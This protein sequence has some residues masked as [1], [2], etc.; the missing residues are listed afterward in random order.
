MQSIYHAANS[1]D[2]HVLVQRLAGHDIEAFVE[3][4]NLQSAGGEMAFGATVR[5][6][7]DGENVDQARALVKVFEEEKRAANTE[8]AAPIGPARS[9][10]LNILLGA[11]L[12]AGAML[13]WHHTPTNK[14]EED[15]NGDGEADLYYVYAPS[16]HVVR[17]DAD[18]NFDGKLDAIYQ[19]DN[20]GHPQSGELDED[21]DG[22]FDL[23]EEYLRGALSA[24]QLN[25]NGNIQEVRSFHYGVLNQ[26]EYLDASSGTPR[27]RA[28]FRAGRLE[29]A[30]LDTDLDGKFDT[31]VQYNVQ[32]DEQGRSFIGA[33]GL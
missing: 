4:E 25:P 11:F 1:I 15:I 2:A 7:V 18:R 29:S 20:G 6:V 27:K 10:L 8:P 30:D 33:P 5:V 12:G 24:Q 22:R 9:A 13:M 17:I 21:F 26:I 14:V 19:Y 23:S 16:G 31:R 32:G 3:G 28:R